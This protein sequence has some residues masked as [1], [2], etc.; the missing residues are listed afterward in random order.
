MSTHLAVAIVADHTADALDKSRSLPPAVT[1]VEYR[2]DKMSEI[3]IEALAAQTPIP[4]IFTCRP[5]SQGGDFGGAEKERRQIL[6]RALGTKHWV[7]IEMAALPALADF[8]S[9]PAR[10]IG[11]Q[12]DFR[13]MLGD[14]ASLSARIHAMGAGIVKLVGMAAT[15]T[16]VLQPLAW[17]AQMTHSAIAIAMGPAG[18]ATRLLSPRFP[19]AFLTF[20]S[21]ETASAPGQIHVKEL[22][23]RYGFTH[24]ANAEPLLAM[25]TPDPVPWELVQRYRR[26]LTAH[27]PAARPWLV[28][29]PIHKLQ[30][31]LMLGLRLARVHGVFR[32]PQV[33]AAASLR[34]YGFDPA[35][36]AWRL[37]NGK[38][39]ALLDPP[40]PQRI[41]SFF[42]QGA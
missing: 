8:I 12:H 15:E 11:S 23:E 37:T 10:V 3:N 19:H 1:L 31:G 5:P 2:L 39:S 40:Q 32:L 6:K 26:A 42:A 34:D 24:I 4:A 16:D 33:A 41:M 13:G 30:P 14:W 36:Y 17:L 18:I 21:L 25:L 29:I 35:G 9:D 38:T 7:D 20:A 28:P 27:F 22:L